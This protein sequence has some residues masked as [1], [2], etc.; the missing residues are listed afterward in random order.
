M[1]FG[2]L[3]FLLIYGAVWALPLQ[4][5]LA[6]P[7]EAPGLRPLVR[8]LGQVQDPAVQRDVLRGIDEALSG[9]RQVAMPEGWP[10][11]YKKLAASPLPEVREKALAL[12]VLFGD[13]QALASLRRTVQNTTA[14]ADTRQR[15][16][17]TLL[18]IKDPQLVPVLQSLL[19]EPALRIPALHGLAAY[20]NESTPQL[21]LK[22]Y[23]SFSDAE[24]S[25]AIQ[26]LASRP[27]S[28]RALLEAVAHGQVPRSDLSAFTVRQLLALHDPA[29]QDKLEKVWGKIQPA[30]HEKAALTAR[31]K[32]LL[33]PNYLKKADLSHGRLIF[34]QTCASCHRLFDA[35]GNVGPELTGSQRANLDYILDNVLDP[36]ALVPQDY[37][38]TILETTDGRVLTGIIKQETDKILTVQT[39]N[40][41]IQVPKDEIE[42]RKKSPLSMMP[43]GLLAKMRD[44]DV[45]DLIAYLASPVQV[46]LPRE[47]VSHR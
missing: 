15:A 31:Y 16:L 24:K 39:Q 7:P 41:R 46:P 2:T 34:S 8:L 40:E 21:I 22:H 37:Q 9:R 42:T 18:D 29:L 28:A 3:T 13:P 30:S 32:A 43:E 4:Q 6:A 36:S 47:A 25:E 17:Q 38:V 27:A 35:G 14:P 33:T 19:A 26:T 44:E 23:A 20:N 45:R 5:A 11:V 12:S 1:R 10:M